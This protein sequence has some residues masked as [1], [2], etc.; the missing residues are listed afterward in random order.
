MSQI[1]NKT[2]D[3]QVSG[4]AN[5]HELKKV[6]SFEISGEDWGDCFGAAAV[7]LAQHDCT[8][9]GVSHYND[10]DD[11]AYCLYLYVEDLQ[12]RK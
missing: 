5:I 2:V 4:G 11:D 3:L 9:I 7:F 10:F 6:Q 12:E 8:L 1:T